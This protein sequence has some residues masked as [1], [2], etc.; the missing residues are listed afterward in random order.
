MYIGCA[1]HYGRASP[2]V[3][4]WRWADT[5]GWSSNTA[6]CWVPTS[7]FGT[8]PFLVRPVSQ[9]WVGR[10]GRVQSPQP[11]VG[12]SAHMH[13]HAHTHSLTHT[14]T[15]M[16]APASFQHT[17]NFLM[18]LRT[19]KRFPL[20]IPNMIRWPVRVSLNTNK[21]DLLHTIG[22]FPSP[23]PPSVWGCPV[24]APWSPM[25]RARRHLHRSYLP[26]LRLPSGPCTRVLRLS[27][28]QQTSGLRGEVRGSWFVVRYYIKWACIRGERG[29]G[30]SSIS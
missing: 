12:L 29:V 30:S 13:T 10:R 5:T 9:P 7:P 17:F 18:K 27:N 19:Y 23:P 16:L 15:H 2:Q 4:N 28:S 6:G 20:N 11:G 3:L 1:P 22:F 25:W 8:R 26:S 24:R 21:Q 14:H